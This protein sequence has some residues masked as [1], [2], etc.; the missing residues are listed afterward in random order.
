MS[1]VKYNGVWVDEMTASQLEAYQRFCDRGKARFDEMVAAK[2]P[3]QIKSSN[4]F[5]AMGK[6][7]GDQFGDGTREFY[8]GSAREA[9]VSTDGKVYDGRLAEFPGDPRAWITSTD[10]TRAIMEERGWGCE[11]DVKVA[12]R[13]PDKIPTPGLD[14]ELVNDLIEDRLVE[15]FGED[16]GGATMKVNE[17]MA[18]KEEVITT[19]SPPDHWKGT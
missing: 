19:H 6:T 5:V 17:F 2:K 16:L 14:P 18:I 12:G 7:G 4:T 3:P 9:G 13:I 15:K 10:D 8:L 1:R 11:G